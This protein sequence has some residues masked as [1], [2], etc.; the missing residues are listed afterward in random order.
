MDVGRIHFLVVVENYILLQPGPPVFPSG[1]PGVSGDFWG[2]QEGCQGPSRPSGE[3]SEGLSG[4]QSG[5]QQTSYLSS[6]AV[7]SRLSRVQLL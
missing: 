7:L 1:E 2:S 4:A 3:P 6:C 5:F